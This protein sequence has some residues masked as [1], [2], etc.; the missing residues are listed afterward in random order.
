MN[1]FL[2]ETK[3]ENHECISVISKDRLSQYI[4]TTVYFM[5]HQ[6]TALRVLESHPALDWFTRKYKR[7]GL[8]L[9]NIPHPPRAGAG[10]GEMYGVIQPGPDSGSS[11]TQS[12]AASSDICLGQGSPRSPNFQPSSASHCGVQLTFLASWLASTGHY[13]PQFSAVGPGSVRSLSVL[14][15]PSRTASLLKC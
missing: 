11:P 15:I 3:T 10:K 13:H 5:L 6:F 1:D 12:E 9:S 14:L 4:N 8:K 7:P 2:G